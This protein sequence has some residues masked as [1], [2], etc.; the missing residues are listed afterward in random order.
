MNKPLEQD[1]PDTRRPIPDS[2]DPMDS[3]LAAP[4]EGDP[5]ADSGL[6]SNESL[7]HEIPA[8]HRDNSAKP[9]RKYF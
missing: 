6:P 4:E 1:S 5:N 3:D 7:P 9:S 2:A 8:E